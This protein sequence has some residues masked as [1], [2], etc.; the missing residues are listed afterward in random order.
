MWW[1]SAGRCV[2]C[3]SAVPPL[4]LRTCQHCTCQHCACTTSRS[5][6]DLPKDLVTGAGAFEIWSAMM[7]AATP[8]VTSGASSMTPPPHS[9]PSTP[10]FLTSPHLTSSQASSHPN[11]LSFLEAPLTPHHPAQ[12]FHDTIN[13]AVDG[14]KAGGHGLV[15]ELI[16]SV[17]GAP[18]SH[19]MP[20]AALALLE[21][22]VALAPKHNA[23]LIAKGAL[24][25]VSHAT[26]GCKRKP[27]SEPPASLQ[28]NSGSLR[29]SLVRGRS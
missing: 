8:E 29:S 25:Q 9:I 2:H 17:V 12:P 1:C 6:Q 15:S 24:V 26:E 28:K 22:G 5:V 3:T 20:A 10:P 23:A 21:K 27:C 13:P 18:R 16:R 14:N 19:S 11:Y 4:C 7:D